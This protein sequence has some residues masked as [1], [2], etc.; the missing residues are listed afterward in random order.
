MRRRE[1]YEY[2]VFFL[3]IRILGWLREGN[4]LEMKNEEI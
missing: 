2:C 4:L 3:K 1:V